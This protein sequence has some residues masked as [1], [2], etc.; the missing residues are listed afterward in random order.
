MENKKYTSLRD[1]ARELGVSV[2]TVSRALHGSKEIS[3]EM[4]ERVQL[5]AKQMNY[6][7]N[8]FAMSLRHNAPHTIG[9]MMPD[10]VTHFYASILKGIEETAVSNDYFVI[11]TSSNESFEHEKR[12]LENLANLRVEG[13]IACLSQETTDYSRFLALKD[14]GLP[15]VFFDRVCLTDQFS[16]VIADGD[17]SAQVATQHLIDSGS[18]RIAFIGGANHLDIVKRRKHGYLE[19]LRQNRMAIEPELVECRKIDYDEGKIATEKLL[20][21]SNPPDAILAMNDTL[22]FAA[23]EVIKSHG[24]RI[25]DDVALIGYTDERHANYVEPK[26]SAIS[27]QT[28]KMGQYACQLMLDQIHGDTDV[29]QIVV[30]TQLHIRESSVKRRTCE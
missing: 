16:S 21:L 15:L 5:L 22:A 1:I 11:I 4:R 20:A 18:R 2:A 26:L 30:P 7:P 27:H 13:I 25:P 23:M 28:Y 12:N 3:R 6:R 8:P 19:A 17:L 24:L 9:V 29:H 14:I 10:I